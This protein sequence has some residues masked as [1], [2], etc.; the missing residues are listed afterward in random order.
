MIKNMC[1]RTCIS[2]PAKTFYFYLLFCMVSAMNVN[3]ADTLA[4]TPGYPGSAHP[5]P[6]LVT[7]TKCHLPSLPSH[8]RGPP[9]SPY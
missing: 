4:Y 8:V 2:L 6:Q 3:R 5:Y 7:P 1:F 9:L